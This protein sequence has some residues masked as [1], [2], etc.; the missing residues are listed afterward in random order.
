MATLD[1]RPSVFVSYSHDSVEHKRQVRQLADRLVQEGGLDVRLDEYEQA[2]PEGWQRWMAAQVHE[3]DFVLMVCTE[4]YRRRV[5][6]REP[7]GRGAGVTWEGALIT[8]EIYDTNG[9]NDRFIPVVLFALE[10]DHVP[11]FMRPYTIYTLSSEEAFHELLQRLHG[12]HLKAR[13]PI[14]PVP[15]FGAA[16]GPS[17]SPHRSQSPSIQLPR[18]YTD[19]D[20]DRFLRESFNFMADYIGAS[21]ERLGTE[22][23]GIEG[24]FVRVDANRFQVSIYRHGNAASKATI[25]LGD[26][27]SYSAGIAFTGSHTTASNTYSEWLSVEADTAGLYFKALMAGL[28]LRQVGDRL[29]CEEA[30]E[31]LWQRFLAPLR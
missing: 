15:T 25:W 2:P 28:G 26:R 3:V 4:T 21:A 30:A 10:R 14:G 24:D 12:V 18:E 27:S 1:R 16:T 17:P 7:P 29:S 22:N 9:H 6:G 31:H 19:R 20:R 11:P 5:E 13:P 8:Q 23:P